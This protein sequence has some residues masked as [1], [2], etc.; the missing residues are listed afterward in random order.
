MKKIET[1]TPEQEAA[2]IAHHAKWFA[3]G[4]CTE[5]PKSISWETDRTPPRL[6][7]ATGPALLFRDGYYLHAWHGT[8]VPSR[9]IEQPESYT[10]E[11]IRQLGNSEVVR[12]L[13][14]R[15]GWD[16]FLKKLGAKVVDTWKDP[17]TA[18]TYELLDTD[19]FGDQQPRLLRMQSP[20][21]LDST[22]PSYIEEV[23]PDVTSARAARFWQF[24]KSSGEWPT[25]KEA[26]DHKRE[27]T[28]T[29]EA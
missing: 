5:R 17:K 23:P 15:L 2:R 11:E 26:N 12:A 7:S 27:L 8:Q 6:H 14:E 3:A 13:A 22:Q 24:R 28:F 19:R 16:E 21:L 9:L 18:L 29:K 4:S 1:L 10:A 25:V 20:V